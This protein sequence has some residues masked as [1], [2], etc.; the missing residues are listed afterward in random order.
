M[1][2]FVPGATDKNPDF[3]FPSGGSTTITYEYTHVTQSSVTATGPGGFSN[4]SSV[5]VTTLGDQTKNGSRTV[6]NLASGQSTFELTVRAINA[7]SVVA[8]AVVFFA[9]AVVADL[10]L[11]D[12]GLRPPRETRSSSW[13]NSA[14]EWTAGWFSKLWF[15]E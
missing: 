15:F 5:S 7:V 8:I 6:S 1:G 9:T 4:L 14:N 13:E 12:L 11:L 10:S 3:L 2:I